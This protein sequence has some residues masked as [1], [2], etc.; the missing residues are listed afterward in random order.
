MSRPLIRRICL[1]NPVPRR[2]LQ[3]VDLFPEQLNDRLVVEDQV[4]VLLA[5]NLLNQ[6]YVLLVDFFE[7]F[8]ITLPLK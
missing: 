5:E 3:D 7:V 8:L 6:L 4:E 1:H 2:R